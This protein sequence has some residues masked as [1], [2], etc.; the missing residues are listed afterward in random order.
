MHVK[1]LN[2]NQIKYIVIIAMLIDHIAWAFVPTKS[3][4]GIAMH[5][6]GRLTGPTMAYFL[7]EGYLHTSN[8]LRYGIR[9][10]IFALISWAPFTLFEE[11][12]W[13]LL[14][15]GVIYT[16][17]WGFIAMCVWENEKIYEPLKYLLLFIIMFVASVGDWSFMDVILPL[18][19]IRYKDD[20]RSKWIGYTI[21]CVV[22][23]VLGFTEGIEKGLFQSGILMVPLLLRFVYNGEPGSKKPFHKWFFYVFYPLHLLILALLV[24]NTIRVFDHRIVIPWN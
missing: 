23:T 12:A 1:G 8:K 2:R 19:V 4:L 22:W 17:F 13:P 3:P 16:L 5:F 7:A 21:M 20:E 24:Y 15:F 6:V 10:G 14:E 18:I 11:G 9:L